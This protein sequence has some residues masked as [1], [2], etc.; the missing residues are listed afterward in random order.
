MGILET[1]ESPA[2]LR[3]LDQ[4]HLTQL[5]DEVRAF[6]VEQTSHSGGHLS[7]NLGVV[8]LTFALHRVFDSPKD[9][10]VW[11]TGHQAYVHKIVTGRSR[12]FARLRQA[13]G[14]SGY[15]SR[16]ESEH[17]FVENSHASTSLSYALGIAEARLRKGV[18]G[19]VI[20]VIGDGALT[21]GMA[22]EAL[23]QIAHLQPPNLIIV[24][25][26]NGRSYAPTVGGLARHLSQLRV[27]PR[28]E[29]IKEEISRLLRDMPLVGPTADQ[30]AYRVKEGLKQLL[31]P[32]TI[33]ESLGIKYAGIVDG[34]DEPALEEVL[35]RSKRLRAP[36]VVH[37]ITEKGHGY[38]P[39]VD[40]EVDKLH[41]VGA[42]DPLTG[43]PRST[44]LT[45]TD[46]FGEA[47]MTAATRRPEVVAIT[48]AMASSTGLLNFAKEFPERFFDVGICEQHAVTFAAGLALAG[49]HPVVC[50]Y[51]TFMARAFDQT[52]MDVA[53][54]KLPV[55][56]IIDR[57]G[58][59]GPDGSSHHGI[60]DLSFLRLIPNLK[61]AAPADATELCA[62]LETALASDGPI[63][64]RYPKGPVPSTP[65]LPVEPL[66][67]GR[68]EQLRKGSDA[69]IFAVGRMVEVAMEAAERL[70][71][72]N[73]SCAVV[74]SRWI[75]PVD[76]RIVDWARTHPV[77]VTVEDNVGA[78]GFGGAVLETLAPHGLAGRVRTLALPDA[79]LPHG[80][81][82]E[83]LKEQGLDSAGVAKAVYEAVKGKVRTET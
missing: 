34:H 38:G 36:T 55:V 78:G 5:A 16:K 19:H 52:I 58:V 48:A 2:D 46:V 61:I 32:S 31:Q 29:R 18:G 67:I 80:K 23:N 40:D 66:P 7:P 26:D 22:Y 65:E 35:S 68:W 37:V 20:A 73:V 69:V 10:I 72:Q 9:A 59:T 79:F 21:G 1:I 3:K 51:S 82:S 76:P 71:L 39:A 43:R 41:G 4:A 17:D 70:E 49:M 30:A 11:D 54:H 15:P 45:Y 64:I 83:I 56:F 75:K 13:G 57:A 47:L 63:A 8:E 28:Y 62:L 42:F 53:L 24:I 44:E 25:N 77:V 27:D 60:F 81:A 6:L 33:F 12:D 50:I 14:L 74:N